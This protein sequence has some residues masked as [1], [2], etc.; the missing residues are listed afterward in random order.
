MVTEELKTWQM[1]LS[2]ICAKLQTA[3]FQMHRVQYKL[4]TIKLKTRGVPNSG[5]R[6]F[7]Q[8]RIL[9]WTI[10]PNKNTNMNSIGSWSFW[11]ASAVLIFTTSLCPSLITAVPVLPSHDPLPFI[12]LIVSQNQAVGARAAGNDWVKSA[13]D[14]ACCTIRILIFVLTTLFVRIRIHYSD[15]YSAPKRIRS[16]YSVHP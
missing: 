4:R 9:L 6:L 5:F 12:R 11:A 15:H 14:I 3:G 1:K 8:I 16:K 10:R 7:G 13:V 2:K